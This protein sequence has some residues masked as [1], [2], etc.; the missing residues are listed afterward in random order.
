[1]D[2]ISPAT[3]RLGPNSSITRSAS[4]YGGKESSSTT[5][6]FV[7]GLH[8]ASLGANTIFLGYVA[9]NIAKD[10]H[11]QKHH[12]LDIIGIAISSLALVCNIFYLGAI[13]K[14]R[15]D[16]RSAATPSTRSN[17]SHSQSYT[18]EHFGKL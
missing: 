7:T 5:S 11:H 17:E 4:R 2:A 13:G 15:W 14:R 10:K 8:I 18:R 12:I 9:H 3:H 6:K 16:N 1:M